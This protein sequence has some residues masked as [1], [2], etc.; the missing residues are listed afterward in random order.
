MFRALAA[1]LIAHERIETTEAKAK[2]LRRVAE[3]LI[4]RA[5]R[6]GEVAYTPHEKLSL[7]D[8]A[9]RQAA[10]RQMSRFLRRFAVVEGKDGESAKV[11]LVE[12][13]FVD[14][15]KRFKDRPGG[16]TRI[17]KLGRRRGDNA[18]MTLIELV[19]GAAQPT[20]GKTAKTDGK[21]PKPAAEAKST[22]KA[23][24]PAEAKAAKPAEAKAAKPAEAKA[25]KPAK[26]A[27]DKPPKAAEAKADKPAKAAEKP[28]KTASKK[29]D[30][31]SDK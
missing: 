19:D 7:A 5:R 29:A 27:A 9:R 1:N 26:K 24:K 2:E 13:V 25:D 17:I 3:R 12:K 31:P 15:A 10:Q 14:L 11:D 30:K 28:A 8:R 20:G 21:S 22:T 6:L 23:A 16:Y 4:T 18:P